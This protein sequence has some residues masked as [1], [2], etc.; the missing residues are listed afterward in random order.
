MKEVLRVLLLFQKLHVVLEFGGS[1]GVFI[2]VSVEQT[3]NSFNLTYE[4]IQDT[5][6]LHNFKKVKILSDFGR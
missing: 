4:P 2:G 1:D 5:H 3:I 6:D